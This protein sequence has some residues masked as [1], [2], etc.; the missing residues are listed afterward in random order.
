MDTLVKNFPN[1]AIPGV[2]DGNILTRPI[3]EALAAGRFAHVPIL[4]GLSHNEEWI[5]VAGAHV[6]V[7][8]GMFVPA[9]TPTDAASYL[10]AI[11]SVLHVSDSRASAVAA[12]YPLNAYP[13]PVLA[14]STLVS[15]A[16]FACPALQVDHWTSRS[17]PTFA[18]EFDD[19]TAPQLFA[20]KL[21][22][23][24]THSSEI[25]YLFDQPNAP[26]AT[27][28]NSTQETLARTMRAAWASFAASGDPGTAATPWPRFDTHS[29]VLSL[30]I[31]AAPGSGELRRN[32]PLRVLGR[33]LTPAHR[34][35]K[36]K[37]CR[38]STSTRRPR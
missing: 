13:A 19:D 24:A 2:V 7:S 38:R 31:A 34:N 17:V 12:E 26:F 3:G 6:A 27:P 8:G 11:A 35:H 36:E 29:S 15:D 33:R 30:Q 32:P 14:L 20:D 25:Q 18:Y 23:I 22:P 5:F 4:N 9:P 21:P 10:S 28:L 1:A 37:P 16:N